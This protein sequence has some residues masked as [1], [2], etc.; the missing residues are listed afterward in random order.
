MPEAAGNP[1]SLQVGQLPERFVRVVIPAKA[2]YDLAAMQKITQS[3]L[4]RLGCTSC[5]SGW[6][7]RFE[8]EREFYVNEQLQVRAAGEIVA[9]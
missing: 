8:L 2:A 5:H 4:G 7:I 3:V 6:D 1:A 9:R